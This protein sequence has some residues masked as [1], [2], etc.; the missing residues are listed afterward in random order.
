MNEFIAN[1]AQSLAVTQ[2]KR[3]LIPCLFE[4]CEVPEIF[5]HMH[6]LNYPRSRNMYNY[7]DKLHK[8][9]VPAP[10]VRMMNGGAVNATSVPLPTISICDVDE[11]TKKSGVSVSTTNQLLP[12]SPKDG[13]LISSFLQLSPSLHGGSAPSLERR[14]TG[15]DESEVRP[16]PRI[17]PPEPR[18]RSATSMLNINL[19]ETFADVA[20][21]VLNG[22]GSSS[23]LNN[24]Y[25]GGGALSTA[26]IDQL[27]ANEHQL[28]ESMS[29]TSETAISYRKKNKF[30]G[31]LKKRFRLSESDAADG[32][33][34]VG[35][36]ELKQKKAKKSIFSTFR[37]AQQK[38]GE[39]EDLSKKKQKKKSKKKCLSI[40]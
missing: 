14:G 38:D 2:R 22:G 37:P 5:R 34:G 27:I 32:G 7:W 8:S 30:F 21:A 23:E 16:Q 10:P 31:F 1:L 33:G 19:N 35:I 40:S 12:P 20:A 26:T 6:L 4:S 17:F 36:E 28:C 9:V 24:N 18:R 11:P 15:V 3:K 39:D 13:A 25:S 29:N